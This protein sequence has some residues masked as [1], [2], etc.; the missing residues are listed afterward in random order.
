MAFNP[1]EASS[2]ILAGRLP[3]TVRSFVFADGTIANTHFVAIPFNAAHK[4]GR[5]RRGRVPAL[6]RG[7]GAE[8]RTSRS[9]ATRPCSTS[10]PSSPPTGRASTALDLGPATLPPDRLGKALPEPHPSW[11]VLLE[12]ALG[13]ALRRLTPIRLLRLAPPLTI[14]LFLGPVAC[15]P[16][17]APSWPAA[18]AGAVAASCW[19]QPGPA[20][21]GIAAHASAA[22]SAPPLLALLAAV[23]IAAARRRAA[24]RRPAPLAAAARAAGRAASGQRHRHRFLAGP[25]RLARAPALALAHRLAAPA[26]PA[27]GQRPVGAGADA[28][29]GVARGALPPAR[30]RRRAEPG[31]QRRATSWRSPAPPATA[32]SEAWLKLVLPRALPADPPA[33]LRRARLRALGRRHGHRP[34]PLGAAGAGGPGPALAD[35]PRPR[36][37]SGRGRRRPAAAGADRG[38]AGRLAP[39]AS[40][41]SPAW[42]GRGWSAGR[43]RC[44]RSRARRRRPP[45]GRRGLRPRSRRPGGA[46]PVVAGRR[47]ALPGRPAAG[48][49]RWRA[50]AGPVSGLAAPTVTT[51]AV[52]LLASLVALAAVL[53][54]LEHEAR[55]G[56]RLR[57]PRPGPGLPAP[58]GPADR[59]PVRAAGAVRPP[60][61]GRDPDRPRLVPSGLRPAL[62]RADAARPLSR[63]RPALARRRQHARPLAGRAVLARAPAAAAPADPGG[64]W[65]WASASAW[66]CTCRRCSSAPGAS[67]RSPPRRWRWPSAATGGSRRWRRLLLAALP[68]VALAAALAVPSAR[69][70]HREPD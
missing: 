20:R 3:D 13:R 34:R 58:A 11:M 15:R 17:S 57:D 19:Q 25:L 65:R 31:R 2:L 7:A 46:R 4:R 38:G 47:L 5:H 18:G 8:S 41:R 23:L 27:H 67:R 66:R 63:L 70:G 40:W 12:K 24:W 53:A 26:R 56:P 62:H 64:R 59:L 1:A 48:A 29:P 60:R 21:A 22:A 44:A 43:H 68:L 50:G 45:R 6:A 61:P 54:C 36:L 35:R 55:A 39:A 33:A 9:G 10:P 42:H 49:G 32:G 51:L 69:L 28:G 16:R 30:D 37:A 14:A 52:G